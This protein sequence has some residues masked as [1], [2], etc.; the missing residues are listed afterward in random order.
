MCWVA[1]VATGFKCVAAGVCAQC[2]CYCAAG[3]H[4]E[5]GWGGLLMLLL[6]LSVW[7]HV[8]VCSVCMLLC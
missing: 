1:H 8:W 2:A 6:G 7:Q 4:E 5:N 3:S